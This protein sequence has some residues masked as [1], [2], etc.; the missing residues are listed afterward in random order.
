MQISMSTPPQVG[1]PFV[2]ARSAA[3]EDLNFRP[4]SKHIHISI[5]PV[6]ATMRSY[7][8]FAA[9]ITALAR[10]H[11]SWSKSMFA[12]LFSTAVRFRMVSQSRYASLITTSDTIL[13]SLFVC[14]HQSSEDLRQFLLT[15][16]LYYIRRRSQEPNPVFLVTGW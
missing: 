5:Y 9:A 1:Q 6:P 4:H 12:N 11:R 3:A 15:Y 13:V 14:L 2:D 10:S 7:S 16:T 8:L